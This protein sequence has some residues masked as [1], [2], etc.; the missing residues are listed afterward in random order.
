MVGVRVAP[1]GWLVQAVTSGSN[2][3]SEPIL[4]AVAFLL[5]GLNALVGVI[6]TRELT[7]LVRGFAG[8]AYGASGCVHH[9]YGSNHDRK[10]VDS[11]IE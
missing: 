1:L 4:M 10:R 2:F 11:A 9:S 5:G 6:V 8:E 7:M 3:T